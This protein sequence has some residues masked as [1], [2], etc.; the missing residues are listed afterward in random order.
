MCVGGC[1]WT[2]VF[3][4]PRT[5]TLLISPIVHQ[6]R[7]DEWGMIRFRCAIDQKPDLSP[8]AARDKNFLMSDL[9]HDIMP[10]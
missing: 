10:N 5:L 2:M 9:S 1:P 4:Y 7:R 6:L 3:P 8:S